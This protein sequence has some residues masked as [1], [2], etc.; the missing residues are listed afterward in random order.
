M[1]DAGST[2]DENAYLY[3]GGTK[4]KTREAA[5]GDGEY[6]DGSREWK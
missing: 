4:E 1:E 6:E 5:T 3:I 2:L